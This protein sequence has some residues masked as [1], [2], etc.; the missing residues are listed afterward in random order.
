MKLTDKTGIW[1][2]KENLYWK[3]KKQLCCKDL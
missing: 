1:D 3:K 2:T